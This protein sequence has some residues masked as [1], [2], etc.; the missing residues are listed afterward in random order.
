ML[1]QTLLKYHNRAIQAADVAR[2]M[3][4]IRK[5]ID[6][7]A[8]RSKALTLSPEEIAFYDAVAANVSSL[9]DS[10]P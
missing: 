5:E 10:M 4:E 2:V 3:I 1:E 6:N 9:F 8:A 7:E